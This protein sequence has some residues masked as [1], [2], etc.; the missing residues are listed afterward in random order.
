[1]N[2][3]NVIALICAIIHII[4]YF[5]LR[6]FP[7]QRSLLMDLMLSV[8]ISMLLYLLAIINTVV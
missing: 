3:V 7:A 4:M 6:L 2:S 8:N 5:L 1:M